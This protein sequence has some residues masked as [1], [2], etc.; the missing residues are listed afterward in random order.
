M[1][2]N[3]GC[4]NFFPS[5]LLSAILAPNSAHVKKLRD[6]ARK[7]GLLINA[8]AGGKTRSVLVLTSGQVI[9]SA[10]RTTTLKS[11]IKKNNTAKKQSEWDK[12]EPF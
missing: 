8:T 11:R 10:L 4:D 9:L 3:I 2:I 12:D 7:K 1:L 5:A 6:E